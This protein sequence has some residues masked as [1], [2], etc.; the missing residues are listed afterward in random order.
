MTDRTDLP[1]VGSTWRHKNGK[2][3]TVVCVAN[4]PELIA[5]DRYEEYPVMISYKT[6]HGGVYGRLL[7]RWHCSMVVDD[8]KEDVDVKPFNLR[9]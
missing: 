3:Y 2:I 6:C 9:P 8:V 5:E 1:K 4:D 7:P